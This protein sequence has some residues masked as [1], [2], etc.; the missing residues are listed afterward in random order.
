MN[1]KLW[2]V[3]EASPFAQA[4][5]DRC[6]IT[7]AL[8]QVL[9]NRNIAETDVPS[10]LEPTIE[11][12]HSSLL[13][14]D[15][16]KAVHRIKTAVSRREKILIAGDY[17]VDGITSAACFYEFIKDYQGL[18]SFYIPHRVK[19]GYGL[20]KE[21]VEKAKRQASA[22]IVCF[23]CGTNSL[24]EIELAAKYGIDV[25]VVDHHHPKDNLNRPYAFVN[26]KRSDSLYPFKDLSA[27]AVSFKLL[28][29]L[30][31]R[32]CRQA[33][34]LVALSLV[35]DVVPLVGENRALLR[36]GLNYIRQSP[37]LAIKA[38][39]RASSLKQESISAF[40]LG[41]ILGPRINAAGRVAH[42]MDSLELF[43]TEDQQKADKIASQ[44]GEFNRLRKNIE[45]EIQKQAQQEIDKDICGRHAIVVSGE[46]WHPG[47]LGIVASRLMDKYWRPAFV[48][49]FEDNVGRGSAR[50]IPGIHLM[51]ALDECRGHLHIYGGHSKAAG[52]HL[53]KEQLDDFKNKI[54]SFVKDN[55]TEESLLRV[56]E[57]DLALTFKD[58]SMPLVEELLKL[59][60]FGEANPKPLFV[61]YGVGKKSAARKI[62]LGFSLWLS[63][64]GMVFEGVVYNRDLMTI[65][66]Y[67]D[68]FD[69][70][71]SLEKNTY[72][73]TPRL[74]IKD[75]RLS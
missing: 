65:L 28:Q 52:L 24:E 50:S 12:L 38:L 40:H 17:D 34:D 71:Y 26:P 58:I 27:G 13:L 42:A 53:F 14:P 5:A 20:K 32:P 41:F 8:A 35:C 1:S 19:E 39:C 10:F 49:S 60:P 22:L 18:F 56:I 44:L 62:P 75:C 55:I 36:E 16:E 3:K 64:Q 37:R 43:L 73:N 66:D 4:F 9:I 25:I 61:S 74:T 21:A 54:N 33:L 23:D 70:V 46:N 11:T 7:S 15:I 48:I 72:H 45:A 6:K 31:G 51:Q 30:T 29:A 69:I 68:N 57:L 47:V 59:E 63:N 2:R 67:G